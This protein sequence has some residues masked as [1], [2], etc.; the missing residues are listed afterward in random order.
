MTNVEPSFKF[1]G[2]LYT[3]AGI[4]VP[5]RTQE[6]TDG[7]TAWNLNQLLEEPKYI[8]TIEQSNLPSE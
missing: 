2:T 6:Q 5:F 3:S 4:G 1:G 7:Q 8:N